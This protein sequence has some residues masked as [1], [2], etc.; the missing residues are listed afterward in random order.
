MINISK[1]EDRVKILEAAYKKGEVSEKKKRSL[2]LIIEWAYEKKHLSQEKYN[3]LL[4]Q[5]K[6]LNVPVVPTQQLNTEQEKPRVMR[7]SQRQLKPKL[8]KKALLYII[9]ILIFSFA[10]AGFGFI[11]SQKPQEQPKVLGDQVQIAG[12]TLRFQGKLIDDQGNAITDKVDATIR[13]YPS[14]F[15]TTPVY[16]GNCFGK[17]A[18]RPSFDG[19]I[20]II[21]GSDCGMAKISE[22][23]LSQNKNLYLGITVG[24]NQEMKPRFLVSAVDYAKNANKVNGMELGTD[25]ST[26]PYIDEEGKVVIGA[27]SP[28]IR[29]T[30]GEFS[31]EG[32][33]V[34]IKTGEDT[35]GSIYFQPD[36]GGSVI[37]PSSKVAIGKENPETE[38]DVVGDASISGNVYFEGEASSFYQNAGGGFAFYTDEDI[39][40]LSKPALK[41]NGGKSSNVEVNG[42]IYLTDNKPQ[43]ATRNKKSLLIG[44]K[45][46]GSIIINSGNKISLGTDQTVAAITVGGDISPSKNGSINL[47]S[48]NNKFDITYTNELV[49]GKEGIGGFWRRKDGYIVPTSIQDDLLLGSDTIQNSSVRIS[50][51]RGGTS[52]IADGLLG[53]G[54]TTPHFQFSASSRVTTSSVAAL[55]NLS[56]SDSTKN[57]LRLNLRNSGS[58][59]NFIEFYKNSSDDNNGQR[60]GSIG[61]DSTSGSLQ[62]KTGAA[63]FAEYMIIN[64]P[65]V[66]GE[67]I[68]ISTKG[69]FRASKNDNILG[70]VSDTAGYIGNT[71]ISEEKG[72]AL[73]G[74]MGQVKTYVSTENGELQSG[75]T[76]SVG[77]IN[78]WGMSANKNDATVGIV[79][80]STE[81]IKQQLKAEYCPVELQKNNIK[82]GRVTILVRPQEAIRTIEEKQERKTR[83]GIVTIGKGST[84]GKV[85]LKGGIAKES[86]I[87]LTP[88][89][90]SP[91]AVS[92][93]KKYSCSSDISSSCESYFIV[94]TDK[95]L[96]ESIDVQWVLTD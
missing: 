6:S 29:S 8:S 27:V 13:L 57:V 46:T 63:D 39:N 48:A 5:V 22:K 76:V 83:K 40:D 66:A 58:N 60:V 50:G 54:T 53:L 31:I 36:I 28:S 45:D 68:G 2:E 9:P 91:V 38:L 92:I 56:E 94:T 87:Q 24:K 23:I 7:Y 85:T 86:Y 26:I 72:A 84:D 82:C 15:S 34:V 52:W 16:E 73:V 64:E 21:V 47:G 44:D 93:S 19:S 4:Q 1:L 33:T 65:V 59:S 30:S 80:D 78:G 20:S 10:L 11:S 51:K 14:Q 96:N 55:S 70:V 77:S 88:L 49:L 17:N 90:E 89:A 18:L 3:S 37:I 12:K 71:S 75:T 61:I 43:I 69:K 95:N 35:A 41:I 32:E 62:Y 42:A 74:L 25:E 81:Q 79:V 67:I